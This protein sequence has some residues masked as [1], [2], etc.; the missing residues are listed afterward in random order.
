MTHKITKQELKEPDSLQVAFWKLVD[1]I[2][3]N[4]K[5]VIITSIGLLAF[6]LAVF[7]WFIYNDRYEKKAQEKYRLAYGFDIKGGLRGSDHALKGYLDLTSSYPRSRAAKLAYYRLGGLYY[8]QDKYDDSILSYEKF[9]KS[10]F[11]DPVLICLANFGIGYA[12]EAKGDYLSAI[13]AF[14]KAMTTYHGDHLAVI[15]NRNI[16]RIYEQMNDIPKSL[17]HYKKALEKAKDPSQELFLKRKL[18]EL[19]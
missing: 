8:Q 7:S 11:P 13:K 6:I 10:S 9:L 3:K 17:E 2:S 15:G 12:L 14:E 19:G 1:Y 4:K 16:A 18:A 5:P